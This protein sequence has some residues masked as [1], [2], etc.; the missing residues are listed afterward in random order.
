MQ[1][2]NIRIDILDVLKQFIETDFQVYD[3]KKYFKSSSF[4]FISVFNQIDRGGEMN[5]GQCH[6]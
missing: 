2:V 6:P 4:M 3:T 5:N 1:L